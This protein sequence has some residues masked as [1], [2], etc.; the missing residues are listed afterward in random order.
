[1]PVKT[2][3]A[4]P[5]Q[6]KT[7][8]VK[9]R[10]VSVESTSS[11]S[12]KVKPFK[13]PGLVLNKQ[14]LNKVVPVAIT[15]FAAGALAAAA[16]KPVKPKPAYV[17]QQ[18]NDSVQLQVNT[19]KS[20]TFRAC[21]EAEAKKIYDLNEKNENNTKI[22]KNQ[23]ERIASLEVENSKMK[24]LVASFD[25]RYGDLKSRLVNSETELKNTQV[26]LETYKKIIENTRR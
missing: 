19:A 2:K 20:E 3:Q 18:D 17:I 23:N 4:K 10:V 12:G 1:M 5:K 26:Q 8:P 16:F 9:K 11:S 24:S 13:R 21:K 14:K 25:S 7:K 15:A 22:I 6:A